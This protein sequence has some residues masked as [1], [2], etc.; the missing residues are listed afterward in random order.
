MR[1]LSSFIAR[2]FK[3]AFALSQ[4]WFEDITTDWKSLANLRGVENQQLLQQLKEA[5]ERAKLLQDQVKSL[6]CQSVTQATPPKLK[7][8]PGHQFDPKLIAV[9]CQLCLI[10]GFRAVPKVL[11]CV[12]KAYNLDLAIPS[13]DAVRNWNCR[14]GVAILAETRR[15]NDWIWLVDHSVQLGQMSV[16]VVLGIRARDVPRKRALRRSD[17]TVLGIMPANSR[18]KHEISKQLKSI[19]DEF[20]KPIATVSDGARELQEALSEVREN[21]EE[22]VCLDDVKHKIAVVLKKE[23]NNNKRWQEFERHLGTTTS[24]IQQ[25][26]LEHLLPPRKKQKCRFMNFDHLVD[27]A[28]KVNLVLLSDQATPRMLEKLGW[29]AGF[30]H[31]LVAWQE[32]RAM[33][34]R[35]LHQTNSQGTWEGSTEQLR[36]ELGK[37]PAST[38]WSIKIREQLTEISQNNELKLKRLSQKGL[39]LPCSTEVLESA[40][41]SFKV[42][43]RNHSRGSFTTLLATFATLFDTCTTAKIRTR[44]ANVTNKKLKAWVRKAGLTNSTQARRMRAPRPK[45]PKLFAE[46]V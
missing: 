8:L 36:Q 45:S 5:E 28:V 44:F 38:L 17:M 22:S 13:H 42:L 4:R 19:A 31:D 20:G 29:V 11:E 3:V 39:V 33:I 15:A 6:S 24:A 30:V 21:P 14:N 25:T 9:C 41:G 16:L 46:A 37:L 1:S 18:T 43:Q 10:T 27:W 12:S 26:E 34:G 32:T 7:C 2:H 40:F 23:L 35:C